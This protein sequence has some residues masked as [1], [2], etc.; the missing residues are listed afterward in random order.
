MV[1]VHYVPCPA[2][3][4]PIQVIT[5]G[6]KDKFMEVKDDTDVHAVKCPDCGQA[7]EVYQKDPDSDMWYFIPRQVQ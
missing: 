6:F 7:Y 4:A 3:E 1:A 5:Y 2:C